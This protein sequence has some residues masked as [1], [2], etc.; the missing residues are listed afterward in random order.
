MLIKL[1]INTKKGTIIR[2]I[3]LVF[4]KGEEKCN[5]LILPV[6]YFG[7]S[8]ASHLV[9]SLEVGAS[10]ELGLQ[11]FIIILSFV[12]SNWEGG[13]KGGAVPWSLKDS[14]FCVPL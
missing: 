4:P 12:C 1:E 11:H 8:N 7:V 13:G 5:Y 14:I 2:K 6:P 3:C 9:S 10:A